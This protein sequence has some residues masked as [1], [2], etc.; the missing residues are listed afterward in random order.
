[1]MAVMPGKVAIESRFYYWR[2]LMDRPVRPGDDKSFQG[3]VNR[4]LD[5]ISA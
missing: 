4:P 3:F 2:W 5:A 1:M